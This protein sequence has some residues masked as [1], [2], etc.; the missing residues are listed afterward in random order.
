[1]GHDVCP[2]PAAAQLHILC[3]CGCWRQLTRYSLMAACLFACRNRAGPQGDRPQHKQAAL[4]AS[5]SGSRAVDSNPRTQPKPRPLCSPPGPR[6]YFHPPHPKAAP[7]TDHTQPP[8]LPCKNPRL[9]R[10]PVEIYFFCPFCLSPSG[11]SLQKCLTSHQ[12]GTWEWGAPQGAAQGLKYKLEGRAQVGEARQHKGHGFSGRDQRFGFL[13]EAV[14]EGWRL[15]SW[16]Q[17]GSEVAPNPGLH[18][19]SPEEK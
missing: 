7:T 15:G 16:G 18:P 6:P 14:P 2:L 19:H 3:L 1:M 11:F 13:Q 17:G 10:G 8:Q 5:G 9:T 4:L 12:R